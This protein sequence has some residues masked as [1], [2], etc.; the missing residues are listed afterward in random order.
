MNQEILDFV[1]ENSEYKKYIVDNKIQW[2]SLGIDIELE[3]SSPD[4]I[5]ETELFISAVS[6]ID[7]V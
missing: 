4:F 5:D 6:A 2:E 3:K 1:E 7:Y